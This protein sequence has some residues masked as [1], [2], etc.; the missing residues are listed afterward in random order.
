MS[1]KFKTFMLSKVIKL[2]LSKKHPILLF[3]FRSMAKKYWATELFAQQRCISMA[4]VTLN[5]ITVLELTMLEQRKF[6]L[7]IVI[8]FNQSLLSH[9]ALEFQS[10][11]FPLLPGKNFLIAL[12]KLW[13]VDSVKSIFLLNFL[14]FKLSKGLLY[15]LSS[16]WNQYYPKPWNILFKE[17]KIYQGFLSDCLQALFCFA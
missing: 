5:C 7:K 4:R 6:T 14:I 12:R 17:R 13:N 15:L 10:I 3:F 8:K 9:R 1:R 11:R 2:F 16:K